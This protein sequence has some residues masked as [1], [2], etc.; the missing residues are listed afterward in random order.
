[1]MNIYQLSL[2]SLSLSLPLFSFQDTVAQF[3]Y[4]IFFLPLIPL[5]LNF[6]SS[7]QKTSVQATVT[8]HTSEMS[9]T[10]LILKSDTRS[11]LVFFVSFHYFQEDK[12]KKKWPFFFFL[13][14]FV[15][16]RPT[17]CLLAV[18]LSIPALLFFIK[19]ITDFIL[20]FKFDAKCI[21]LISDSDFATEYRIGDH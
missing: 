4:A 6:I 13:I 16:I 11:L 12:Q 5:G 20:F 9:S 7:L 10:C 17:F 21:L 14:V 8:Q 3:Q 2:T 1:M 15:I 19:Q 18:I